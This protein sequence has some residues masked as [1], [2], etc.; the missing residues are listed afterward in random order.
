MTT[1]DTERWD[2]RTRRLIGDAAADRLAASHVL[3]AGLG[4]VGGY[5]AEMLARSGVGA[6]TII[7]ADNVAPSNI[8]RQLIASLPTIGVPK[9]VLFA[10]RFHEINP[11]ARITALREYIDADAIPPLLGLSPE[12]GAHAARPD[13]VVDA[14]DTVAPKCGLIMTC[15]SHGIPVISSMGAGGRVDPTKVGYSDLW[16]VKGDGLARAVR[17]RFKKLGWHRS[18]KC[19]WSAETP[20]M[21][22]AIPVEGL[23]GKKTSPGTIATVPAIFGI[24]LA[25]YVIKR[26]TEQSH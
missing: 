13:F 6:L 20:D 2:D 8:N 16:D 11:A 22:S 4:G 3:V 26:L 5:A 12:E 7:D 17:A 15:R 14:I 24:L 19:V 25:S 23:P 18:L 9:A 1:P 21:S 10:E